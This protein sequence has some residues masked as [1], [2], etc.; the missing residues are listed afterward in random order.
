MKL[1]IGLQFLNILRTL[2][3]S[4]YLDFMGLTQIVQ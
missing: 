1:E 3:S 4:A 2:V